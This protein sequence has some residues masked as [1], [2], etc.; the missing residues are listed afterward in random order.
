MNL[1]ADESVDGAI[2]RRLRD[3]GHDVEYVAELASGIPDDE[4]LE[5]ARTANR[6]LLTADK[7][8]GELVFRLGQTHTGIVLLRLAGRPAAERADIVA[9]VIRERETE[10]PGRFAVVTP[11]AVRIR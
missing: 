9:R 3:E 4:V 1:F 5:R 11:D 7:D 2:V 6:V 8:F 10:L